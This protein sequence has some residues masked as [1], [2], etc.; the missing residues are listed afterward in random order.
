M[1]ERTLLVAAHPD[2]IETMLGNQALVSAEAGHH[3]YAIVAT[4]GE[5]SS[6]DY[7]SDRRLCR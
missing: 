2:D 3:T 7:S 5:A 6:I 4:N 1:T